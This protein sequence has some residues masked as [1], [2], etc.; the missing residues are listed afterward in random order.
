[1]SGERG[2]Q[3]GTVDAVDEHAPMI[4]TAL[5]SWTVDG[6]PAIATAA[7]IDYMARSLA[8]QAFQFYKRH[9]QSGR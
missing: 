8:W 7:A 6:E 4:A 2:E 1:M 3:G 5:R 9:S